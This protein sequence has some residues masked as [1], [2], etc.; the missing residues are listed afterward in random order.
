MDQAAGDNLEAAGGTIRCAM[1]AIAGPNKNLF[2]WAWRGPV[3][4]RNLKP[5]N[6]RHRCGNEG[7]TVEQTL[8]LFRDR[9]VK[10]VP[11]KPFHGNFTVG[12]FGLC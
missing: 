11:K 12:F 8:S 4:E 2:E 1:E 6:A 7:V 10:V 3:V 9:T 5:E